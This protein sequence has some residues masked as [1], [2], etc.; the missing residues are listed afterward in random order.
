[1]S[2]ATVDSNQ[3]RPTG[4]TWTVNA[5]MTTVM[6]A[7]PGRQVTGEVTVVDAVDVPIAHALVT[8][9]IDTAP[10]TASITDRPTRFINPPTPTFKFAST[11][12]GSTFR[13]AIDGGAATS[14]AS[15]FTTPALADGA[16]DL[17]VTAVDPAG[18]VDTTGE[19]R[20]FSVDA[21]APRLVLTSRPPA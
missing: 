14:C 11:E 8:F 5:T 2:L 3:L 10:P 21:T 9:R 16:H 17:A 19:T 15:P 12:A 18:N 1:G 4:S 20:S 6:A 13:C 7:G